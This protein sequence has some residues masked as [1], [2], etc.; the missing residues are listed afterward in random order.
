MR[1]E[2]TTLLFLVKCSLSCLALM[3][4]CRAKTPS[5]TLHTRATL[6][7]FGLIG[8]IFR[9]DAPHATASA[10]HSCSII[11]SVPPIWLRPKWPTS[12]R[13]PRHRPPRPTVKTPPRAKK[14]LQH[15]RDR[16]Q[17]TS[18]P[19]TKEPTTTALGS[20]AEAAAF[21]LSGRFCCCF[22]PPGTVE[23]R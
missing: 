23:K 5:C 3:C 4:C 6:Q 21:R 1:S 7:Q 10:H 14:T 11:R 12:Q 22:R 8:Q 19:R 15:A 18:G 2:H 20:A 17:T 16:I 9:G 13:T